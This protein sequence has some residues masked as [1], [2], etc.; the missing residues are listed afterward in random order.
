MAGYSQNGLRYAKLQSS[1]P[2]VLSGANPSDNKGRG[3]MYLMA[4]TLPVDPLGYYLLQPR[5]DRP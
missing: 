4:Q 2:P 5:G 1:V 3:I